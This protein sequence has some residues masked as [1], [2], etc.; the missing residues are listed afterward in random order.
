MTS[1]QAARLMLDEC[2]SINDLIQRRLP[3]T[4]AA[5]RRYCYGNSRR[6]PDR[7]ADTLKEI[8]RA[9]RENDTGRHDPAAAGN[10]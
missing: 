9:R 6:I 10:R 1:R 5:L 3:F 8:A 7:L 2:L 4:E